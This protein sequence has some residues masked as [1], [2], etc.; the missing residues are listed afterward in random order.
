M[1]SDIPCVGTYEIR[2]TIAGLPDY[3]KKQ[4][5]YFKDHIA[6]MR[7]SL[8]GAGFKLQQPNIAR[9]K[10]TT[11]LGFFPRQNAKGASY[12]TDRSKPESS[13]EL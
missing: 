1:D 11:K 5:D 6:K 12:Q 2:P 9:S 13:Q 8:N 4:I 10:S 3:H 7:S